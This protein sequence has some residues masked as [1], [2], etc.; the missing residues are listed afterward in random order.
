VIGFAAVKAGRSRPLLKLATF[1]TF[2]SSAASA[3]AAAAALAGLASASGCKSCDNGSS[4]DAVDAGRH[5][6]PTSLTPEQAKQT[7]AK[8][9]DETI[10][11]GDYAAALEHMDQFDRLRY[12]SVE[13]RKELL[14][15]MITVKLLAKEATD[16]GYDKDPIAQQEMR[17]VLRDS[18]LAEARKNA[19]S[20]ADVPEADVHKWFEDHR[21]EYKDPERRRISVIV[22][23]DEAT[24]R[25]A[26]AAA[27]KVTD[28]SQWGE[29][30]RAKSIDPQARA[31]VPVD[32]A[33]DVGIV[34]PPGD[35]RGE[36]ARV[37]EEVRAAAFAIPEVGGTADKVVSS[38]GKLYVVRLTQKLPSHE[39]TFEEA[40]RSIRVKLSQDKLRAKEDELIAELRKSVKVEIDEGALSSVKLDMGDAGN[41]DAGH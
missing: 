19:P 29:L 1:A 3:L 16:K 32:L 31:N 38:Q 20:P 9:G 40:E 8:V 34:S 39:R 5:E 2:V 22:V 10:T 7:L 37:P 11:L 41:A 30:V 23:R 18:M 28:A 17:A 26:L 13:R 15:E 24:A 14:D 36:N 12:Q 25:D 21:A 6:N 35:P 4:V 33:G 27:K